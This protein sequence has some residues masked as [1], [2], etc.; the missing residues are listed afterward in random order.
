M[1]VGSAFTQTGFELRVAFV[2]L[3]LAGV[4]QRIDRVAHDL[5]EIDRPALQ[6]DLAH[7]DARRVEQVVRQLAEMPHLP[8]NDRLGVLLHVLALSLLR[9]LQQ[10]R[11][12]RDRRE[13][14]AQLVAE[15]RE[16]LVLGLVGQLRGEPRVLFEQPRLSLAVQQLV[17]LDVC[18]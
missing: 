6:H 12:R 7:H 15:H 3:Q 2:T 14:I 10:L 11:R 1:R 18:G 17:A 16:K 9:V 5:R 4:A 8:A 13:R